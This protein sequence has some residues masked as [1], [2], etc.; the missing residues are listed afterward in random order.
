MTLLSPLTP[1]VVLRVSDRRV[2]FVQGNRVMP[3]DDLFNKAIVYDGRVCFPYAAMAEVLGERTD[4]WLA[5]VLA[6]SGALDN[7][8]E[9]LRQTCTEVFSHGK[10]EELPLGVVAAGWSCRPPDGQLAPFYSVISNFFINGRWARN[11]GT[12]DPSQRVEYPFRRGFRDAIE[13]RWLP[14]PSGGNRFDP[15]RVHQTWSPGGAEAG[16]ALQPMCGRV[17][18]TLRDEGPSLS[19]TRGALPW[20]M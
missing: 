9:L 18:D 8:F 16:R 6:E 13:T 14:C 4:V 7:G 20:D 1:S 17:S 12:P 2:S 3:R 10:M 15:G 19:A 11:S 5:K